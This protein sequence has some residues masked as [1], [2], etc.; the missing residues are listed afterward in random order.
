MR[1]FVYVHAYVRVCTFCNTLPHIE[2]G[3]DG[4]APPPPH[5]EK[6]PTPMLHVQSNLG[7]LN[8]SY[9]KL[10]GYSKTMDSPDF[11][12]YYLLQ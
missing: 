1:T 5:I 6:L 3:L 11:Y 12:L 10:L 9:P 8:A 7:Y 4:F 2:V